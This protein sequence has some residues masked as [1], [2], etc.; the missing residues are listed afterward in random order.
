MVDALQQVG[1]ARSIVIDEHD[2][3]L[4]G[5]G[6]TQAAAEAGITKV[7]VIEADGH[8]LIAVRRRGLTDDQKRLLAMYDNRSAELAEWN[9]PQL[10]A[11]AIAGL[12]LQPFFFASE[13]VTLLG[14]QAKPGQT[15]PDAAPDPRPT[16]IQPGDLFTLG[17]HR[18][19]CGDATVAGDVARLTEGDPTPPFLL[20]TDPPYGVHYDP[21]WRQDAAEKGFIGFGATRLGT[22][23]NDDRS[24]WTHAYTLFRGD[25]AYVWHAVIHP[26]DVPGVDQ[27]LI[28]ASFEIRSQIIW[29]KRSFAISR[30]HYH[31]QHEPCWYAVRKG[32]AARWC[33]DRSQA[34]VWDIDAVGMSHKQGEDLE[35]PHGTQKP[36][37]CMA[38]AI[39]HHG[40]AGDLVYD[41]FLGSGTT[42]I[43]AEQYGRSCRAIELSPTYCQVTIDRW[44]AFTG[45]TA[46]KV[47]EAVRP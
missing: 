42:L 44:E 19:L 1:A 23:P 18:L 35:T 39:R 40:E 2:V 4:A 13:L 14:P 45:Q 47:G 3:I 20:V 36:I 7:R 5:N 43:A 41:P 29:R 12:D 22:V 31:W 32:K 33:G 17:M 26:P 27:Q 38:R 46:V 15:A 37:E 16:D 8:E 21:Q 6:V 24:D 10:Q 11:D 25:V 30:G 9:L 34:T 28:A